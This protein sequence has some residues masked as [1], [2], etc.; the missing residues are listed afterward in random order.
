MNNQVPKVFLDFIIKTRCYLN[1]LF[2][3]LTH[4]SDFSYPPSVIAHFV[5]S[6]FIF[7]LLNLDRK[8]VV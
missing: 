1:P 3:F 5:N 4:I 7:L 6:G 2:D 8:S